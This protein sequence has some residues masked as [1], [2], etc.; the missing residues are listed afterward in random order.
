MTDRLTDRER[1]KLIADARGGVLE[2]Q[3]ADDLSLLAGVLG[4]SS[5]WV[6][7]DARLE[8]AVVRAVADAE[9]AATPPP[10]RVARTAARRR[11]RVL[12]ST[13]AAAAV[14]AIVVA[15]VVL[16]RGGTSADYQAQLRATGSAPGAEATADITRTDA[17]FQ[18]TLD[19][20]GLPAL[21]GGEYYQAWLRNA[22]GTLVPIGS[23]SSSDG[24]AT[25]WSGVSPKDF[26]TITVTIEATDN[27]QRSSGRRVLVG[28]VRAE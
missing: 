11:R 9:P 17:G 25:L 16:T 23:F 6:E 22:A 21:G 10:A 7:P 27:D 15:S 24:R 8:D 1:E 13:V 2:P 26:P 3:E 18:I 12:V 28:E 5:T 20:D 14:I 19:A 4:D